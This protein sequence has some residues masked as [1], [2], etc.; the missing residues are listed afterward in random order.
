MKK[1]T[2]SKKRK[3]LTIYLICGA[4][5]VAISGT[6]AVYTSQVFQ[7]SVVRNRDNEFIRFS[8]DKLYCV[9]EGT[10]AQR[11]YYPMG[12]D[13]R[14]MTFQVCNYAQE[15]NTLFNDKTIEYEI[16]FEVDNGTVG[17]SYAVSDGK[18]TKSV[19]TG[20]TVSFQADLQG[21]RRS[22]NSYSFTFSEMDY[23]NLKLLV[24]VMPTD[25]STT[26]KRILNGILI[27]VEYATTQGI[28]VKSEYTDSTRGTPDQFDAYNLLVSVSGGEGNV[29][30]TWN[31]KMLDID[32]FFASGKSIVRNGDESTVTLQMN[33]EDE[34]G[35]YLISFYNHNITKPTWTAWK[36]LPITVKLENTPET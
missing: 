2:A 10:E 23:N 29:L 34:T 11:Y 19:T 21:K 35:A 30:I 15:K 13:Q 24:T 17:Y 25:S 26:Q 8:S 33:S 7:R 14:T 9:A 28:T 5:L 22:S 18:E 4:I 32:P 12:K 1:G 36:D 16:N 20:N 31:H 6:L 3:K 27:P